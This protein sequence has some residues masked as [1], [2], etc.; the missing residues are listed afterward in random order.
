MGL[1]FSGSLI[2]FCGTG[3]VTL[4]LG[5]FA[6][7]WY[8]GVYTYLKR[9]TAFA[10]IP[11]ALIGVIPPALGWV[12]GGGSI[13]D[14]RLWGISF[15]FFIWQVPHFWLLFLNFSRDYERAGLPSLTKIFSPEQ[16]RRIIFFWILSTAVSSLIIPLFDLVSFYSTFF[17]TLVATLWLVRNA[18]H[19]L[20]SYSEGASLQKTFIKLNVYAFLVMSLLSFEKLFDSRDINLTV[21]SRVLAIMGI[22]HV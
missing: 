17:L 16:L 12:S 22:K 9:K 14:S 3:P 11:G 21:I 18:M 6:V 1:I 19:L 8:N 10:T 2:L 4:A 5:L 7:L 15:F 20:T 13:L